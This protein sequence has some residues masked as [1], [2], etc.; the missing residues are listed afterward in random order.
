MAKV[1]LV[2][3]DEDV[4]TV[5]G[6]YLERDG[7][8]VWPARTAGEAL[9]EAAAHPDVVILDLTL[10]DLDGLRVLGHLR[11]DGD[12]PVLVL[13]ARGEE[14]DRLL[15]LGLGADDY[16]VKPFSPREVCLRVAAL[17]RRSTVRPQAED[18]EALLFGDVEL[19]P[20]EHRVR[21]HGRELDLTPREFDLLE[22]FLRHPRQVL[23]RQAILL[24]LWSDGFVSDHVV[25]V[26][27]ASL[28]RKLGHTAAIENVRG[29][30]Y[31]LALGS[32]S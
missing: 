15:G 9:R 14:S 3:D 12:M 24:A 6:R 21:V 18:V 7:H 25:D 23:S 20:S 1:L 26:H 11:Q 8:S 16:V 2:D 13:S 17:V 22:L 29:I 10:P 30:G 5:L 32:M 28:R 19:R 31:R 4:Q 27:L